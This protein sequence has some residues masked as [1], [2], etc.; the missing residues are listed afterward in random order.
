MNEFISNWGGIIGAILSTIT[1]GGIMIKFLKNNLIQI[2][3]R[4]NE[5]QNQ[6]IKDIKENLEKIQNTTND[7]QHNGQA[8]RIAMQ[9]ALRSTITNIYFKYKDKD[10]IPYYEKENLEKLYRAYRDIGGNSFVEDLYTK[11]IT[12]KVE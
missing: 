8:D 10:S 7:L 5:P 9:A 2:I 11:L 6:D 1:L 3:D 4:A 12:K